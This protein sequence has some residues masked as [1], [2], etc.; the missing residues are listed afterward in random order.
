M[1]FAAESINHLMKKLN[2][3][4]GTFE[5][6]HISNEKQSVLTLY[7]SKTKYPECKH[8]IYPRFFPQ[9]FY[10]LDMNRLSVQ[11]TMLFRGHEAYRY[12]G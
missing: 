11:Y 9:L 8:V 1:I 4:M 7:L 5:C 12:T 2:H 3:I 10:H 6:Q